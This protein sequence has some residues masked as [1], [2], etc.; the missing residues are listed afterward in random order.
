MGHAASMYLVDQGNP[1]CVPRV[2]CYQAI[3]QLCGRE[4]L[5]AAFAWHMAGQQLLQGRYLV[6]FCTPMRYRGLHSLQSKDR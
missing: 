1:G 2:M 3:S 4:L 6:T 5:V